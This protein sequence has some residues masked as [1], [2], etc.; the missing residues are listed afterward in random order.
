MV[1]YLL[2]SG[3]IVPT[4]SLLMGSISVYSLIVKLKDMRDEIQNVNHEKTDSKV[5]TNIVLWW[6]GTF[7]GKRLHDMMS[8][9]LS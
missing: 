9:K 2:L 6:A 1:S 4:Y 5:N 7:L 8:E 3:A